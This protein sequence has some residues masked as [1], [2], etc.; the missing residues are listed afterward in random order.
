[1]KPSFFVKAN[2][3]IN[4]F[5]VVNDVAF[6][7]VIGIMVKRIGNRFGQINAL[8]EIG[9]VIYSVFFDLSDANGF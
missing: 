5:K 4:L 8:Q 3:H 9:I 6:I 1:M 7:V 2:V